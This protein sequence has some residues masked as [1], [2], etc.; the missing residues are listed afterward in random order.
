MKDIAEI[1]KNL[2]VETEIHREGL[3]FFD[4]DQAPFQI[5]G[6][7]KE[8]GVYRRMP[9]AV[10]E[11]V[12]E[13]VMGL[14][15][16]AAGGRIRFVT[17]SPYVAIKVK[18]GT[19]KMSHFALTGSAGFDMFAE[20]NGKHRYA[21]SFLPPFAFK[22]EYEAV[23]DF[24]LEYAEDNTCEKIITLNMPLYST[25]VSLYIGLKEGS[26]LKAAPDYSNEKPVVY[27]GSSI[28]QGG[29]ASKPGSSYQSILSR[30][31][32]LD[33]INLGFSGSAKAEDVMID[34]IKGLDM[35]LFV[36]DYDHN[37]PDIDHL[38]A[39]HSKMFKAIREAHPEIPILIL[40]R[41]RYYLTP[42]DRKRF[43]I[44]HDTYLE[45]KANGDENVYFLTGKELMALVED[46]GS[47]DGTH[48]T[49]SGFHSMAQA[50]G[51]VFEEI[52]NKKDEK[53]A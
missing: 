14:H 43:E 29:C 22:S 7:F 17:D 21:G 33:Y 19:W 9:K 47:V 4:P 15:T 48:P 45:A 41:P 49:D 30:R 52:F 24:D 36:Y 28:T 10:A 13:G 51:K 42:D 6:V 26:V 8:D 11:Q 20:Y 40:P 18:M 46:N 35:S 34:Y 32:N 5:Y 50:I 27:Y 31:F 25:V 12:S 44:I 37:A 23:K 53:N 38:R 2:K 16:H 39:T 1:D 3:V